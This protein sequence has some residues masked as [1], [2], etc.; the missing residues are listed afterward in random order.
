LVR[1]IS[2][3]ITVNN[4][5][6]HPSKKDAEQLFGD[7]HH[8]S[9][10]PSPDKHL[11]PG[12]I[13]WKEKVTVSGP[14]GS[15]SNVSLLGPLSE[16]TSIEMSTT[17]AYRLGL[18]TEDIK[19][20]KFSPGVTVTGPKGNVFVP[21]HQPVNGRWLLVS[22]DLSVKHGLKDGMFVDAHVGADSDWATTFHKVRVI[23]E[24]EG[25]WALYLDPDAASAASVKPGDTAKVLLP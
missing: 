22:K 18:G 10:D 7:S 11:W 21:I 23:I 15:I 17:D 1:E 5:H 9:P 6:V 25:R 16:K 19:N 14:S 13:L 4:R 24:G 12:H 20:K 8:F 2:V 3:P